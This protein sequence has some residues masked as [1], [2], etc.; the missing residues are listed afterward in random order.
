MDRGIS[1]P[2]GRAS[3]RLSA[4]SFTVSSSSPISISNL[5]PKPPSSLAVGD[6]FG[7]HPSLGST[8]T[9]RSPTTT[10]GIVLF[11]S[12]KTSCHFTNASIPLTSKVL[13]VSTD[14][15]LHPGMF[16]LLGQIFAHELTNR[17]RTLQLTVGWN[18]L[19]EPFYKPSKA[20]FSALKKLLL[21][22]CV[23]TLTLR[24]MNEPGRCDPF[25]VDPEF[26]YRQQHLS[27]SP[28]LDG[29]SPSISVVLHHWS[30]VRSSAA[31]RQSAPPPLV[32]SSLRVLRRQS[33]SSSSPP[34]P[35]PSAD[36]SFS[37]RFFRRRRSPSAALDIHQPPSIPRLQSPRVSSL[38][39]SSIFFW[40]P[41]AALNLTISMLASNELGTEQGSSISKFPQPVS[42]HIIMER[43][44]NSNKGG[45]GKRKRTLVNASK[46]KRPP[47]IPLES[48]A[49]A[50]RVAPT[51][52]RVALNISYSPLPSPLE[53]AVITSASTIVRPIVNQFIKPT[54]STGG[55]KLPTVLQ[56]AD[57]DDSESETGEEDDYE[58]EPCMEGAE[59]DDGH[60]SFNM[61]FDV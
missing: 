25:W 61:V 55:S 45:T 6:P 46:K 57:E 30:A 42:S 11:N 24:T 26:D 19:V 23:M 32:G 44:C 22:R 38:F 16:N 53:D 56:A 52:S 40:Y 7:N 10:N 33:I 17:V 14:V 50:S 35:S 39:S 2:A 59:D 51:I 20:N 36:S 58:S 21:Y 27:L 29:D 60:G 5:P 31:G 49:S 43:G 18:H 28:S 54:T 47:H 13:S 1:P 8:S 3:D 12:S 4:L 15:N 48:S 41:L 34:P 37:R 9:S